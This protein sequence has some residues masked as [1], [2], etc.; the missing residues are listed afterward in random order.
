MSST[1]VYRY[2]DVKYCAVIVNALEGEKC[3]QSDKEKVFAG[4]QNAHRGKDS[5]AHT[6]IVSQD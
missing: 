5:P 3:K 4:K 6:V 2:V 1:I